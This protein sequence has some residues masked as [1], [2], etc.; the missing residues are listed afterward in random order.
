MTGYIRGQ[1]LLS[2]LIA[3]L[4]GIGMWL[5]GVPHPL[6]LAAVAFVFECVPVVGFWIMGA[7]CVI[8]ALTQGWSTA[9]FALGYFV[10]ASNIEANIAAPRILGR[11]VHVHPVVSLL[12]L[13]A[14]AEAFGLWGALFAAPAI[15]IAQALLSAEWTGWRETHP[16]EFPEVVASEQSAASEEAPPDSP[17]GHDS[18]QASRYSA[19]RASA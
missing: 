1:M 6:F 10:I 15:G 12:A 5:L 8:M 2:F 16:R 11:A 14:G 7:V 9:L 18:Q 13:L 19:E 4:V 3:A 17:G